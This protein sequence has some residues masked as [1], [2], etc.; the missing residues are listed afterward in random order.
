MLSRPRDVLPA[1]RGRAVPSSRAW[2]VC[3]AQSA[4]RVVRVIR[5]PSSLEIRVIRGLEAHSQRELECPRQRVGRGAH[6]L[7]EV[8]A[9]I[10]VHAL[11][12]GL[13]EWIE[14]L[15]P[16]RIVDGGQDGRI[17]S[18]AV[19]VEQLELIEQV[20]HLDLS[21]E[22]GLPAEPVPVVQ[23]EVRAEHRLGTER[24]PVCEPV[25]HGCRRLTVARVVDELARVDAAE[26]AV[27]RAGVDLL[28]EPGREGSQSFG[29]RQLPC[30]PHAHA[31]PL[32]GCQVACRRR[33]RQVDVL[34]VARE[35]AGDGAAIGGFAVDV[36]PQPRQRVV[37]AE[38]H[39][40][41]EAVVGLD[42]AGKVLHASSG[43]CSHEREIEHLS[44]FVG[45]LSGRQVDAIAVEVREVAVDEVE[46]QRAAAA[47]LTAQPAR[48]FVGMRRDQRVADLRLDAGDACEERIPV[49]PAAGIEP[50]ENLAQ[51]RVR[52]DERRRR[53]AVLIPGPW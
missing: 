9:V 44:D 11:H 45:H 53:G 31:V 41:A 40:G 15:E 34:G 6:G 35:A 4:S 42:A 27:R 19:D 33:P 2:S 32:I 14:G 39:F 5:V 47:E 7:A 29:D 23:R 26:R 21:E 8:F 20:Q 49:G 1:A 37:A 43:R 17:D 16:I 51:R 30:A 25:V 3:S 48:E 22:L 18:V 24:V 28:E 36:A 46:A 13:R 38:V 10:P 12:G 52:C 50:V